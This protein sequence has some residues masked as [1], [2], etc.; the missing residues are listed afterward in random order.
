MPER[1]A[2]PRGGL[3]TIR[4]A[5]KLLSL[6]AEGP[7][8]QHLTDLAERSGMS[9]PTVHRLLRSLVIAD[10][11]IQDP[12]TLRYGLGPEIS[13]L[14]THYLSKHPVLNAVSPFVVALRD[15]L[16]ATIS[17]SIL[18]GHELVCLDQVDAGDQGPF[19]SPPTS[20]PALASAPGR[21]LA[22]RTDDEHWQFILSQASADLAATAEQNRQ[23]WANAEDLFMGPTD[24]LRP[25][26]VAVLIK[27]ADDDVVAAL[28][29]AVA[30]N[31]SSVDLS[32]VVDILTRTAVSCKGNLRNG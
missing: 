30:P 7:A 12:T 8:L 6:L 9:V 5:T 31:T 27:D 4:N 10:F 20:T 16:Q 25:A 18:V 11:A 23:E 24:V 22:S 21:L 1:N 32:K 13:R 17:T 14:S 2:S 19:R 28:S 29:A 26:E 15:Q 3:G